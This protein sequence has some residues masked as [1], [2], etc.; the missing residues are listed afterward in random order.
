MQFH[1]AHFHAHPGP[2]PGF[3]GAP[4]PA[5]AHP[6]NPAGAPP[7]E[8]A[9]PPA[10]GPTLRDRIERR[11][12]EAGLR[13]CDASCGVGPSDEDPFV[14]V[15]E[16]ARRVVPLG[17]GHSFHPACLVS[18]QRVRGG[19]REPVLGGAEG[20]GKEGEVEVVC[21]LCRAEGHVPQAEWL[22]GCIL[23]LD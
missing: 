2:P 17:C 22:A 11:E 14:E 13:C 6:G 7:Q 16:A 18:A 19:W 1:T 21:S 5:S 23:P 15:R 20:E 3:H 9:P 12:R 8:W 4:A 10:P